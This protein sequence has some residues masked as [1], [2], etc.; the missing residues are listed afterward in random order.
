MTLETARAI[1]ELSEERGERASNPPHLGDV[2]IGESDVGVDVEYRP[3][4]FDLERWV[5]LHERPFRDGEIDMSLFPADAEIGGPQSELRNLSDAASQ[6]LGFSTDD[7]ISVLTRALR[8]C[9]DSGH[10]FVGFSGS[11][12]GPEFPDAAIDYL[13]FSD[14]HLTLKDLRPSATRH[15]RR[16]VWTSPLLK[17]GEQ[18]FIHRDLV[19]EA[20]IRWAR[21]L[22]VGDWPV[23]RNV[24]QKTSP[25]L[26]RA[27]ENRSRESGPS[28]EQYVARRLD[29]TGLLHVSMKN[30]ARVGTLNLS[31]EIDAVVVDPV[32]RKLHVLEFK[33]TRSDQNARSL[34]SELEKFLG[35][36]AEKLMRSVREVEAEKVAFVA[37]VYELRGVAQE[38][39][40]DPASW[41]VEAAFVFSSHSPIECLTAP[42]AFAGINADDV[43]ELFRP[44]KQR[45]D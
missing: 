22:S 16:R 11:P 17:S 9:T 19:F 44:E 33:N 6:D 5:Q 45:V 18:Y 42:Q 29:E 23:P 20:L 10:Q 34:Q 2:R 26:Y 31:R 32:R 3:G 39:V 25:H 4:D 37:K 38:E 43:H 30:G 28:F 15:Q 36:Y 35:S 24:L 7:L 41:G 1:A 14:E 40:V 13:T 8:L 12:F 27:V 21:Y